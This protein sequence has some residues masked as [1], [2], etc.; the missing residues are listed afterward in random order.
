MFAASAAAEASLARMQRKNVETEGQGLAEGSSTKNSGVRATFE[1]NDDG[2][3][4]NTF[5][6]D[7]L[8]GLDATTGEERFGVEGFEKVKGG[9]LQ[10]GVEIGANGEIRYVDKEWTNVAATDKLDGLT[11]DSAETNT[12]VTAAGVKSRRARQ[13]GL[14]KEDENSNGRIIHKRQLIDDDNEGSGDNPYVEIVNRYAAQVIKRMQ[15]R[16]T[17]MYCLLCLFFQPCMATP[18]LSSL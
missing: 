14:G 4:V 2:T 18:I 5:D 10:L 15:A 7:A 9:L 17:L 13:S 6:I 12:E 3:N 8:Y 1:L 11:G 16:A